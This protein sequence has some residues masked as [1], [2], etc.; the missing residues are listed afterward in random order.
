MKIKD[1]FSPK[2]K[3]SNPQERLNAVMNLPCN[4][5]L[6]EVIL[7]DQNR[8]VVLAAL[9]RVRNPLFF[10]SWIEDELPPGHPFKKEIV[11]RYEELLYKA[12]ISTKVNLNE[13]EFD[14]ILRSLKNSEK[15][16]EL[17]HEIKDEEKRLKILQRLD[18]EKALYKFL[19]D[20]EPNINFEI[21][22]EKIND[23]DILRKLTTFAK[24]KKLKRL[25]EKKLEGLKRNYQNL[26]NAEVRQHL[27]AVISELKLIRK[28]RE[29][30]RAESEMTSLEERWNKIDPG[31]KHTLRQEFN[32]I[33]SQIREGLSL[34]QEL[35]RSMAELLKK[36]ESGQKV[37][38]EE[39][40][41]PN[42]NH[43]SEKELK[44]WKQKIFGS[45]ENTAEI[46]LSPHEQQALRSESKRQQNESEAQE[47]QKLFY[48]GK[49]LEEIKRLQKDV[50]VQ[51]LS[52]ISAHKR[53][54][55]I[56]THWD[57]D[58]TPTFENNPIRHEFDNIKIGLSNILNDAVALHEEKLQKEEAR[59]KRAYEIVH[60][61][62]EIINGEDNK[63]RPLR[64]LQDEFEKILAETNIER[65]LVKAYRNNLDRFYKELKQHKEDRHWEEWANYK[66]R[67]E[68]CQEL[69]L[70]ASDL[71]QEFIG[72]KLLEILSKWKNAG[73]VSKEQ[74]EELHQKFKPIADQII[75]SCL[76]KKRECLSRLKEEL[77]ILDDET[78]EINY[79]GLNERVEAIQ[80]EWR[81]AGQLP[82]AVER[83]Y[84][85]QFNK[86]KSYFFKKKESFFQERD[87]E[88]AQNL[89]N[90]IRLLAETERVIKEPY[91]KKI[92]LDKV[93]DF[94]RRWKEIGPIPKGVT[95]DP[96]VH[97]KKL[98]DDFY[99]GLQE[100]KQEIVAQK[101][102]LLK[103]LQEVL[104]TIDHVD[105]SEFEEKQQKV[106]EL[107][108]SWK[109]IAIS[110]REHDQQFHALVDQFY[111]QK[112]EKFEKLKR[113]KQ[114]MIKAKLSLLTTME[115]EYPNLAHESALTSLNELRPKFQEATTQDEGL[116]ATLHERMLRIFRTIEAEKSLWEQEPEGENSDTLRDYQ[117]IINQLAVISRI[118][119]PQNS[120]EASSGVTL[121]LAEQLEYGLKFK[122]LIVDKDNPD[123][124]R[125]NALSEVFK[126]Q[127]KWIKLAPI[128]SGRPEKQALWKAYKGVLSSIF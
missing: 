69:Q 59:K 43:L 54:Q 53:L 37:T 57:R 97:F 74:F 104:A 91:D 33:L 117:D 122:A 78:A 17:A 98:C 39:F 123:K 103:G 93:R 70:L 65:D 2:W 61:I 55:D 1:F 35:N 18:S 111:R 110:S 38:I 102:E 96:W 121:T 9:K 125:E 80:E 114:E 15:L 109:D 8:D 124:N 27:E 83:D 47:K 99:E 19:K 29:W 115:G 116:D 67:Q 86:L 63:H 22:M 26:S 4:D 64:P 12:M 72:N 25:A 76:D 32:L 88:R 14:L 60:D 87:K 112:N 11:E 89:E 84:V 23:G 75:Q 21:L 58:Y 94:Q 107:Q 28:E 10:E 113:A 85:D 49:R 81:R 52:A 3:H 41:R 30:E 73:R 6:K 101:V 16:L 106:S 36:K 90:K 95:D 100:E 68:L 45:N 126:L 127:D 105:L 118:L 128:F 42:L 66:Y 20:Y 108:E 24:N 44:D 120:F 71:H 119:S 40:R 51:K 46:M 62:Q 5:D 48:L 50:E 56:V 34:Y 7:R 79:R 13:D 31:S 77:K 92:K 82:M